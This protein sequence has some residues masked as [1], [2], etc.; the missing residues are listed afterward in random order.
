MGIQDKLNDAEFKCLRRAYKKLNKDS[1]TCI[2]K[3]RNWRDSVEKFFGKIDDTE[4]LIE[5]LQYHKNKA[6]SS[7]EFI[8]NLLINSVAA[9]VIVYLINS[10]I[11]KFIDFGIIQI[12]WIAFVTVFIISFISTWFKLD[13]RFYE[14]CLDII[15][16]NKN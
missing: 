16:S 8:D 1:I 2:T 7:S 15:N 6:N 3:Y 13:V 5:W 12:I 14:E 4:M 11:E 10:G 9:T